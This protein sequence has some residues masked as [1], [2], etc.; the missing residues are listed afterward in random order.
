VEA[1]LADLQ[2]PR[3]IPLDVRYV[4]LGQVDP[5]WVVHLSEPGRFGSMELAFD[6]GEDE[7]G[8]RLLYRLAHQLTDTFISETHGA[9]GEARPVCPGHRH[10]AC[11]ELLEGEAWWICPTD[12]HRV[13]R[14]GGTR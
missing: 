13:K 6:E 1:V 3:P 5:V 14:I 2:A 9:W 4:R 8:E 7:A 10:P 12:R 11:A